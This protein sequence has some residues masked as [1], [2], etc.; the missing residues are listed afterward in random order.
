MNLGG[1]GER[2][3]EREREREEREEREKREREERE[4]R[5]GIPAS[6]CPVRSSVCIAG[7]PAL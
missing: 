1:T 5:V 6:I 4:N 3:R 7:E 2:Q